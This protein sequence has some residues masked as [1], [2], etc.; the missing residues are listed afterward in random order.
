MVI[1]H[2]VPVKA[3]G[4][5]DDTN[6]IALC[7]NCHAIVHSVEPGNEA[8]FHGLDL[9]LETFMPYEQRCKIDDLIFKHASSLYWN[10]PPVEIPDEDEE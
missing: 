10:N 6:L 4:A 5:G 3:L 9:W 1:H 8:E 2:I 7:P